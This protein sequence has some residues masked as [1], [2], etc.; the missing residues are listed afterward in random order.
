MGFLSY[1]KHFQTFSLVLPAIVHDVVKLDWVFVRLP[2][3]KRIIGRTRERLV[4]RPKRKGFS[5]QLSSDWGI[6]LRY[7][8][9]GMRYIVPLLHRKQSSYPCGAN[10]RVLVLVT[11]SRFGNRTF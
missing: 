11:F 10:E 3:R 6:T 7:C 1:V 4:T 8:L 9:L 5:D 2:F